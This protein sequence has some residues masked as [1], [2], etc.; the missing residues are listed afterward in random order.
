MVMARAFGGA[1]RYHVFGQGADEPEPVA[2]IQF[3]RGSSGEYR[4]RP[5]SLTEART[6]LW[7]AN[8]STL[9][10]R[11]ASS[12]LPCSMA[13]VTASPTPMSTSI[14]AWSASPSASSQARPR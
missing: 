2:A 13:L 14:T 5:V 10:R 4:H 9:T 12:W 8:I 7:S 6:A 11:V 3:L 1:N